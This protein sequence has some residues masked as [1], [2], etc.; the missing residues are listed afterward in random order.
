MDQAAIA[1]QW[2][3]IEAVW[4]HGTCVEGRVYRVTPFGAFLDLG[5]RFSGLL[6]YPDSSRPPQRS[7]VEGQVVRAAVV[8][9]HPGL[10]Q[11]KLTTEPDACPPDVDPVPPP[12]HLR[13]APSPLSENFEPRR[14]AR[15]T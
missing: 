6:E 14:R 3:E 12:P 5:I 1:D 9:P 11:I 2:E 10:G 8:R 13:C 4:P 15:S 7:F